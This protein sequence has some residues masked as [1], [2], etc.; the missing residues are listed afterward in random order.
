VIEYDGASYIAHRDN[1]GIP[2]EDGWQILFG[3]GSRGP[4][5]D[6]GPWRRKGE[7]SARGE[8]A[9]TIVNWTLDRKTIARSRRCQTEELER[10]SNC[11]NRNKRGDNRFKFR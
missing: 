11:V 1:P 2:G 3:R 7:R 6:V 8:D 10:R 4:V 9:P 5:G